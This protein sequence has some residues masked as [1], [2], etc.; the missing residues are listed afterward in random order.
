MI[1]ANRGRAFIVCN[2]LDRGEVSLHE[3]RLLRQFQQA[4]NSDYVMDELASGIKSVCEQNHIGFSEIY[5]N[6]QDKDYHKVNVAGGNEPGE[7]IVMLPYRSIMCRG[8]GYFLKYWQSYR[9]T[10]D[11]PLP[12]TSGVMIDDADAVENIFRHAKSLG[13]S[14][15]MQIP[16]DFNIWNQL[17]SGQCFRF[18][19]IFARTLGME[20][21]TAVEPELKDVIRS[22][23]SIRPAAIFFHGNMKTNIHALIAELEYTPHLY[24]LCRG[25]GD[26]KFYAQ[27]Q[28]AYRYTYDY[29]S[30]G[31]AAA[32]LLLKP[33]LKYPKREL[34]YVKGKL[35]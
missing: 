5:L 19:E 3:I 18:G 12:G 6:L 22:I 14:S 10:V 27:I 34:V 26:D 33:A 17:F 15:I 16:H 24:F 29:R 1:A 32:E 23:N 11:M 9:V 7:G 21:F 8:A 20:H 35:K 25:E 13:A 4:D 2:P 30:M 31:K 28:G